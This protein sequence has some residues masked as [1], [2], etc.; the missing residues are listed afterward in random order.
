MLTHAYIDDEEGFDTSMLGNKSIDDFLS[1]KPKF[2]E[3]FVKEEP[4]WNEQ[5]E[6]TWL[7][8]ALPQ[9]N[10]DERL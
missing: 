3:S 4:I 9:F 10:R 8:R 7:E 6:R 5:K 2:L 1:S